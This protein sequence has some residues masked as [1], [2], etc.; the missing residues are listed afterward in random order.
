MMTSK[1][2]LSLQGV[3]K[4]GELNAPP[5]GLKPGIYLPERSR[6]FENPL[7]RTKVRGWHSSRGAL[8]QQKKNRVLTQKL[9]PDVFSILYGP[10]KV[11]P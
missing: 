3:E 2:S 9:K 6:G 11:V 1:A 5:P 7:P 4:A 10:T 8:I